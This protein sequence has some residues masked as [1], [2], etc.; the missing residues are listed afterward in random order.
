MNLEE[1]KQLVR[2]AKTDPEAFGRLYD[3]YYSKIFGYVLKRTGNLEISKD[4]VS[5]IFIKAL[6]NINKFKWQN[7]LGF[8]PSFGSWLYRIASN[9]IANFFRRQKPTI[10]LDSIADPRFD[11]NLLDEIMK[12]EEKLKDHQDFLSIQREIMLLSPKYQEVLVLRFFEKK[13]IKEISEIIGKNQGTVKSLL[14]RGLAKL[15][16][17]TPLIKD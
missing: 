1:E 11:F 7:I 5:E 3:Q 2:E 15:R 17:Q 12:A 8:G 16:E 13:K 4:I 14:H 9:E 10:S 6:K